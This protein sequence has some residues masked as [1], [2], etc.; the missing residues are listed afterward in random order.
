VNV[1]ST[2]ESKLLAKAAKQAYFTLGLPNLLPAEFEL[3]KEVW[4]RITGLF[5]AKIVWGIE[6]KDYEGVEFYQK[7]LDFIHDLKPYTGK[8]DLNP[9]E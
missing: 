4:C 6:A 1:T 3:A 9:P 2:V 8:E 5:E 7:L